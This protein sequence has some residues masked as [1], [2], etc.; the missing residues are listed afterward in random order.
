MVPTRSPFRAAEENQMS[1]ASRHPLARKMEERSMRKTLSNL[2]NDFI[3]LFGDV[4]I[5]LIEV[6][7]LDAEERAEIRDVLE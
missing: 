4:R 7:G 1:R 6:N 5:Y 2:F 3:F